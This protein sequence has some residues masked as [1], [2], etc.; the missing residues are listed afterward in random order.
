MSLGMSLENQMK[1]KYILEADTA[2]VGD[3]YMREIIARLSICRAG[4]S[5]PSFTERRHSRGRPQAGECK[6]SFGL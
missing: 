2:G 6:L 3:W 1:V 4:L 5:A